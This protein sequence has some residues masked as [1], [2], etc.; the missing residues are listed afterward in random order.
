MSNQP[1][2]EPLTDE[3]RELDEALRVTG[4]FWVLGTVPLT[5]LSLLLRKLSKRSKSPGTELSSRGSILE[6]SLKVERQEAP[7]TYLT[8]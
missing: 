1:H 3:G 6:S 2:E 5:P 8:V 4:L 7:E